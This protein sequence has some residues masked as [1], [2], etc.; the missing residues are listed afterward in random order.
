MPKVFVT[1]IFFLDISFT[2]TICQK[3]ILRSIVV[4]S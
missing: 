4:W 3:I 1:V 2:K